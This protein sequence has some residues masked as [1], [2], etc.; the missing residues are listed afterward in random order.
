LNF[1]PIGNVCAH[2]RRPGTIGSRILA[3]ANGLVN[4]FGL[5]CIRANIFD[6]KKNVSALCATRDKLCGLQNKT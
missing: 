4:A 6:D 1:L 5:A 3:G 2:R